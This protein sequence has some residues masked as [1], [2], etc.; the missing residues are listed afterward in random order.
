[1][2]KPKLAITMGDPAGTGPEQALLALTHPEVSESSTPIVFGDASVLERVAS[3]AG[4]EPPE[5]VVPIEEWL[6]CHADFETPVVVDLCVV[7]PDELVC[8]STDAKTGQTSF[9]YLVQ[10]VEAARAGQ[11]QG[12]V[13]GP[14]DA[15]AW[16]AAEVDY[17][18]ERDF[19]AAMFDEAKVS[20]ILIG[21][22][23]VCALGSGPVPPA[24]AMES[25]TEEGMQSLI[26]RVAEFVRV[27]WDREP[28]VIV[29]GIDPRGGGEVDEAIIGPAVRAAFGSG[30]H[31]DGPF[32]AEEVFNP[33]ERE[34]AD[35]VVSPLWDVGRV[36]FGLINAG[37]AGVEFT[38]GLPVPHT[39]PMGGAGLSMAWQGR[40]NPEAMFEACRVAAKLIRGEGAVGVL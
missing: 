37:N 30:M 21:E 35:V 25:L 10:A 3:Q 28:D 24:E 32:P 22:R 26:Q 8:G 34:R 2:E 33:D 40:A 27:V 13:S 9:E 15:S 17:A 31:C 12:I 14:I 4:L 1:M 6:S 18:N 11:V 7:T 29:C 23:M 38:S 19:L 39:R 16:R 20:S 5:L 36:A